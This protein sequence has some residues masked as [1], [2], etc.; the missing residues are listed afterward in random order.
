MNEE[1]PYYPYRLR[2]WQTGNE[3]VPAWRVS[4][5]NAYNLVIS[6]LWLSAIKKLFELEGETGDW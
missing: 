4:L 5:E 2:L 6:G 1:R 3:E